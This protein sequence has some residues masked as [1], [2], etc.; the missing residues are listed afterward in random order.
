ML[1]TI[2]GLR[3]LVLRTLYHHRWNN[4]RA[5]S[6]KQSFFADASKISANHVK[7]FVDIEEILRRAARFFCDFSIYRQVGYD[8]ITRG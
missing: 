8:E 6:R 5:K 1:L 7:C 2:V 3:V 4:A